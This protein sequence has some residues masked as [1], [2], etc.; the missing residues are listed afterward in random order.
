MNSTEIAN[1]EPSGAA[2]AISSETRAMTLGQK[3]EYAKLLADSGM[4]PKHYQK[5]P[6][7]CLV[8]IE[9]GEALD[10]APIVAINQITVV[11]GGA[12]MEAKLMIALARKAGHKVRLSGDEKTATCVI[13][14]ADDPGHESIVTWDEAKAK[15]SKLWGG[16]HWEKNPGLMLRYRAAAECIRL[17]CPEVLAGITYTPD[18]MEEITRRNT[19]AT[20]VTQVD[21]P[22]PARTA[23]Y[24]MRALRLNGMQFK[25][26]AGRVLG[27]D[28]GSWER[29][30]AADQDS[31]LE[32]LGVWEATGEDPTIT[33]VDGEI[34]DTLT[35]EMPLI[36][37]D[38][39]QA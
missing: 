29:M 22:Q 16:G 32:Q 23:A 17:T 18:E 27:H 14:R 34:V 13:V 2:A 21:T 19:R 8:A 7:N 4:I 37:E 38:G 3:V 28:P 24:F 25:Q 30:P 36:T 11:N 9:Y 5:H 1:V 39:D 35:G 20:T 10:I 6:A 33:A 31:V 12:S 15:K 26:F